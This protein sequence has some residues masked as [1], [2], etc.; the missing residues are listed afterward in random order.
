MMTAMWRT[1]L[2]RAFLLFWELPQNILG[3]SLYGLQRARGNVKQTRFERERIMI[4][5]SPT[6][7]ISLGLFVFYTNEDNFY[8]PVGRE[9]IDHEYGH[10][11]QSRWL[12]PL[13]LLVV[14]VTSELRV[15][16]A[17]AHRIIKGKRWGGYYS[18]FPEN[19]ADRLGKVDASVRPAA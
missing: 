1:N 16:Y 15:A 8:V 2:R 19:W 3:A 4:E 10:S 12:G 7:A 13:Y 6:G 9:N 5:T 18:G 17:L 14:G 11:V